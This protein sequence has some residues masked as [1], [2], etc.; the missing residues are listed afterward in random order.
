MAKDRAIERIDRAG[1]DGDSNYLADLI[2]KPDLAPEVRDHLATVVFGLLTGK[3]KRPAHRPKSQKIEQD[4]K[5]I[6]KQVLVLNRWQGWEKRIAAV[7]HVAQKLG[8]GEQKVWNAL[9]DHGF[10]A[11]RNLD[12]REFEILDDANTAMREAAVNSLNDK[13]GDREFTHEEVKAEADELAESLA[14]YLFR[15]NP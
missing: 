6:A 9:R 12:K 13:Y 3:I 1:H 4:A 10:E 8:C 15:L 7:K 5:E 14:D 2:R 11:E